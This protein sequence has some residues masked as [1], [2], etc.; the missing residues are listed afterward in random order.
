MDEFQRL[1]E[2]QDRKSASKYLRDLNKKIMRRIACRLIHTGQENDQYI[3]GITFIQAR[4]IKELRT[5]LTYEEA[6]DELG[7]S[8]KSLKK[9]ICQGLAVHDGK[10]PRFAVEIMKEDPAYF[11]L[12]QMEF[13]KQNSKTQTE[14]DR[15]ENIRSRIMEFE[16]AYGGKFEELFGH[17]TDEEIDFLDD[18]MDLMVWK[19]LIEEI[20]VLKYKTEE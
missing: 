3:A 18:G 9:Y 8:E 15:I 14:E 1:I 4:E 20:R 12:M 6:M 13:Q 17:L 19:N 7:L 5:Y 11:I 16:E 10:I 2:I